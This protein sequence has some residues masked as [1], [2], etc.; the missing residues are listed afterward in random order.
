MI[1]FQITIQGLTEMNGHYHTL[2]HLKMLGR[3]G[4]V[5]AEKRDFI[6]QS[7]KAG[8]H[9]PPLVKVNGYF[10][11]L[12]KGTYNLKFTIEDANDGRTIDYSQ[13]VVIAL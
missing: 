9:G 7:L 11:G 8:S 3:K 10:S 4:E 1:N 2:V 13:S 6:D 12:E 5:L